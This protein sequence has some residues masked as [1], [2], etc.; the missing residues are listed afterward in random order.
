VDHINS[1]DILQTENNL[2]K[3]LERNQFLLHYQPK[4]DLKTGKLQGAE[5]LLRW[6]HPKK[7]L[8]SPLEFIPI[9]EETGQII[10]IGE[11]V[12]RTACEQGKEWLNSGI[13]PMVISV[14]LSAR[15]FFQPN[16]VEVVQKIIEETGF[17]PE[18]LE[19][20]ITESIMMNAPEVLYILQD[21]KRIGLQISLDDFGTGYSS[22]YYLREFPI[23]KVKIDQSF[24]RNCMVDTKDATIVKAIIAMSHQLQLEVI[25]EGIEYKDQLIFLQQNLCNHGQGYF[26][27]K[28]LPPT[29]FIRYLVDFEKILIKEGI[30][31]EL[32]KQ[33]WLEE[34]L[35]NARQELRDTVRQ[36]QAMIFKFKEKDGRFIHTLCDGELLYRMGFTPESVIGKE[37]NDF[38]PP[39]IAKEKTEYFCRAWNGEENVKY[40]AK[41]NGIWYL[42]TLRPIRRGG[43]VIEVIGSGVDITHQKVMEKRLRE[44][45]YNY[46]LIAEN[47]QDLIRVLKT[48]FI[49]KYASPSHKFILGYSPKCF[50]G[51][52]I[53]DFIHPDDVQK[54]RLHYS[55]SLYTKKPFRVEYRNK[56]IKSDWVDVEAHVTPV[57]NENG[58]VEYLVVVGRD[59]SERKKTEEQFRKSEKLSLVG[60]LASSIA[61]EIRNPLTTIKGFVQLLKK[62][63]KKPLYI[64][65]TLSEIHRIE[66]ILEEFIAFAKHQNHKII[67]LNINELL[68]QVLNLLC[69]QTVMKNIELIQ[70]CQSD[71]PTIH[72]DESQIK[73]VFIHILHN[74][75]EAMPNGGTIK[76]QTLS[77]DA[78]NIKIKFIDNGVG[79]SEDRIKNIGEPVYNL[80]EKGSGFGLM[81]CHKIIQEHAGTINI[82]SKINQGTTVEVILPISNILIDNN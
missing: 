48:S 62:E 76:I 41:V 26:F 80:K 32:S 59:I 39:S 21:L 67:E 47:T 74:A 25:A 82:K 68:K 17:S 65:T 79:M 49:I 18:Y 1:D 54:V 10:P 11:W 52:V 69:S 44:S 24:V 33:K 15:Q 58:E 30:S 7:G 27:S 16:L 43:Q 57:L 63:V 66:E 61:H 14:N 71:L 19:L 34:E 53:F 20:E 29:E 23:D 9:A 64:Q 4:L 35:A 50:Q 12:L 8:I 36:Q 72:C 46:R 6:N 78:S 75:T 5:A 3:A 40:E 56:H 45:E 31:Q 77:Q 2:G 28:P 60:R 38:L 22:L 37:L 42:A 73:Q 13:T 51:N 81:V 55:Q 70:D